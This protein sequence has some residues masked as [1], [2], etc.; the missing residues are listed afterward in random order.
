[1]AWAWALRNSSQHT[2]QSTEHAHT[3]A[4]DG[5]ATIASLWQQKQTHYK[6]H[7]RTPSIHLAIQILTFRLTFIVCKLYSQYREHRSLCSYSYEICVYVHSF[8]FNSISLVWC[9]YELYI[10]GNETQQ[11]LLNN[12]NRVNVSVIESRSKLE[13]SCF[14]FREQ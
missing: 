7:T 4:I 3:V 2:S 12:E 13:R 10:L 9:A 1:M 6:L 11:W 5:D 8:K 14:D